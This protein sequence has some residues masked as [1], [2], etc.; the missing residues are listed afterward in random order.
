MYRWW[1]RGRFTF[2]SVPSYI[3]L[4]TFKHNKGDFST[5]RFA[6]RRSVYT[7][8]VSSFFNFLLFIVFSQKRFLRASSGV[9]CTARGIV[10]SDFPARHGRRRA[11]GYYWK[12]L[13]LSLFSQEGFFFSFRALTHTCVYSMVN[14]IHVCMCVCARVKRYLNG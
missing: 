9:W 11:A 8:F 6:L 3:Y 5:P 10:C 7:F 14:I 4:I 13:L 2:A 1:R 12:T